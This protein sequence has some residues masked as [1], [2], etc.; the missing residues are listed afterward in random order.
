V[1][2]VLANTVTKTAIA[3]SLGAP[4]LRRALLFTTGL[5]LLSA[6]GGVFIASQW[7]PT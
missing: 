6:I 3:V 2:A 4:E 5:L 1:I 7:G